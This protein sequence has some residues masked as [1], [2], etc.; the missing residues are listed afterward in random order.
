[1]PIYCPTCNR[2]S[3]DCLFVGDFCEFCIAEKLRKKIPKGMTI[4]QCRFCNRVKVGNTFIEPG[5]EKRV[6]GK[7]IKHMLKNEYEVGVLEFGRNNIA[8]CMLTKALDGGD[9]KFE[10]D[11]TIK[12]LHETCQRCFRI[13]AGYYQG[14]IQLRGDRS[15]MDRMMG[16]LSRYEE[17]R[18]GY[19]TK[20]EDVSNG[21]D[22]Y[23]SNK[24][25]ANNFFIDHDLKP[26]RSFRLWGVKKGK[27]VYRNTYSLHL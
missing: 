26:L 4:F 16:K 2:S 27:K 24:E 19:I 1:M 8:K 17:R 25:A 22:I 21:I 10:V 5:N 15:K 20:V 7:A 9:I 23:V 14:I 6:L 18:G 13:S 12:R 3:D 11:I